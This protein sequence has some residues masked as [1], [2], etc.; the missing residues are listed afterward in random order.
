MR[1]DIAEILNDRK[2]RGDARIDAL[3][4]LFDP[5]IYEAWPHKTRVEVEQ[6][7]AYG[8]ELGLDANG[9]ACRV[10]FPYGAQIDG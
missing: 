3:E 10:T 2:L 5:E 1:D 9:E 4:A 6:V 7:Q 8:L